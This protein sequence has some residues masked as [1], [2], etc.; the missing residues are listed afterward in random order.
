VEGG[1]WGVKG[2]SVRESNPAMRWVLTGIVSRLLGMDPG[3]VC[4][5]HLLVAL[6]IRG[7]GIAPVAEDL[8]GESRRGSWPG[9][10]PPGREA[11]RSQHL[12]GTQLLASNTGAI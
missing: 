10:Q 11:D 3:A 1:W 2:W 8:P 4:V 7:H 5:S 12:H 6:Q 9:R